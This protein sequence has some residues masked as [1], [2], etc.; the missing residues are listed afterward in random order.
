MQEKERELSLARSLA[1]AIGAADFFGKT[2]QHA[3]HEKHQRDRG[4]G[5][6]ALVRQ[7]LRCRSMGGGES[8][9][10]REHG[11]RKREE[12]KTKNEC[13]LP[14]LSLEDE[15]VKSEGAKGEGGK[16][17]LASSHSF[18]A[19]NQSISTSNL[20]KVSAERCLRPF[21][22]FLFRSLPCICIVV[23][24]GRKVRREAVQQERGG[25]REIWK[26][27]D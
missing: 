25:G 12:P 26:R 15:E 1:L 2:H 5:S 21:S 20:P 11:W 6:K 17:T 9:G 24:E 16:K 3:Q 22:L 4:R 13:S 27:A 7:Q 18:S 14:K 8:P 19:A 10:G 23:K